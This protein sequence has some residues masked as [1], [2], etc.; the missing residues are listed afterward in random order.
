MKLDK[1]TIAAFNDSIER[2]QSDPKFLSLFYQKF[3]ISNSE[4][5]E[6]F[7]NTDM[8]QQKMMLH[9]SLYMIMFSI[10]GNEAASVYLDRVAYRHSK[11]ELDIRPELYDLWLIT[12]IETVSEI[13]PLF[14][15]KVES[16]WNKVMTH[17]IEYMKSKY[18][19][20]E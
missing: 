20:G 3:V 18:E 13:D 2:C 17:G 11:S 15:N 6:K 7:A 5:R 10:Q 4:V 8:A 14:N 9:A 12:L 16:A 1:K 19:S